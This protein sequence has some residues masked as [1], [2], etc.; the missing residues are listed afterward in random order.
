MIYIVYFLW[1]GVVFIRLEHGYLDGDIRVPVRK[2]RFTLFCFHIIAFALLYGYFFSLEGSFRVLI[3]FGCSTGVLIYA[4]VGITRIYRNVGILMNGVLFLLDI[5]WV[6]LYRLSEVKDGVL[7]PS[8]VEKQLMLCT[9][10]VA[11]ITVLPIFFKLVKDLDRARVLYLVLGFGL[12]VAPTFIG[13]EE[14]GATNWIKIGSFGFQ[15]SE[16]AKVLFVLYF[17]CAMHKKNSL[18]SILVNCGIAATFV[19]VLILQKDLGGALIFFMTFMVILYSATG[20]ELL[21]FGG[22]SAAA[23]GAYIALR[24]FTHFQDR[25]AAWQ[26]PWPIIDKVGYQITQSLFAICT[27]GPFG[28][29][30]T[31]GYASVV[32][33]V[34]RDFIFAAICEE[35]GWVFGLLVIAVFIMVLYRG[36]HIALRARGAINSLISVAFTAMLG[37]Q[38]FI[39]LGGVIK[40]IPMTGVT[41]P[42]IS[43][44]GTSVV[45]CIVILGVL[46][47]IQSD[48]EEEKMGEEAGLEEW[49]IEEV[50]FEE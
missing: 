5:G 10:G 33:V 4:V 22:F 36:V 41:L 34:K 46:L 9:A 27:W 40:L 43:Y 30:L 18:T 35:F 28:S 25:V 16:P 29:G 12:I 20:S 6:I 13:A 48:S 49:E 14:F 2:Q 1:Q 42:F 31:R 47:Y 45:V 44:G 38:T 24:L 21:F 17:A 19:A 11:A 3:F 7:D 50:K 15:P 39:I 8:L 37:F 23:A 26:N 32:P